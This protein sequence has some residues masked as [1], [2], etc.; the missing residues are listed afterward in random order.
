MKK[1]NRVSDTGQREK[2]QIFSETRQ[3][4]DIRYIPNIFHNNDQIA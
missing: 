4:L 2:N 3:K 1:T